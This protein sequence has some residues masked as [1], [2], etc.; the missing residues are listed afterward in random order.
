MKETEY[1]VA[2]YSFTDAQAYKEAKREAESIEYIKANTDLSDLN[3]AVKLYQKLTER[4]TLKT[5]VGYGFL[6]EL[7]ERILKEGILSQENI[8]GIPV[9]KDEIIVKAYKTQLDQESEKKHQQIVEDYRIKLKNSRIISLF[10]AL[11]IIGMLVIAFLN[12][13]VIINNKE[14]EIINKYSQWKEELEAR[15]KALE[16]REAALSA[17]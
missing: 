5:V 3:K 17:E 1:K 4:K 12:D 14:T 16:E 2:G 7:Q 10:L 15:E 11:I 6:K 9:E 8:P 13:N